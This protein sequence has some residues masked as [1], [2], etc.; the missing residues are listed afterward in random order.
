MLR[1]TAATDPWALTLD[2]VV[3][4]LGSQ[5]WG[6][7]TRRSARGSLRSWWRWGVATGRTTED[8]GA[9]IEPVPIAPPTPRLADPGGVVV[10]M[11]EADARV[12]LMLRMAT[13]LGM[14]RGE[15]ARVHTDDLVRD[16]TGWS[17]RVRGKG[18]R[19]RTIPLPDDIA[20]QIAAASPGYVFPGR[21]DGHLSARWV[22]KLVSRMLPGTDTM[23]S[24][25]H[26]AA[27]SLHDRTRDLRLV[28]RVLGHASLETTQVYVHV[29]DD[30]MRRAIV[31]H[32]A[33]W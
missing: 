18:R 32:A 9:M 25:R 10:A 28:Q 27:T 1:E 6:W 2:D 12:L 19:D 13:G 20:R 17:L 5:S 26:L 7:E 21:E 3:G 11:R 22:G 24:L 8:V 30:A 33:S 29:S 14:R 16:L 23:H 15:V 31:E 4:W